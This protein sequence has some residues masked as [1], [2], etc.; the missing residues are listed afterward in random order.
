M[1]TALFSITAEQAAHDQR[2]C[3][4]M[5]K[6]LDRQIKAQFH[7]PYDAFKGT[8]DRADILY[9]LSGR[10]VNYIHRGKIIIRAGKILSVEAWK[11]LAKE[12]SDAETTK[13]RNMVHPAYDAQKIVEDLLTFLHQ[14]GYALELP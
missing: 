13:Y 6:E 10:F 4:F 8:G 2:I 5:A 11:S 12:F 14:R 9:I 1:T 3:E 7:Y